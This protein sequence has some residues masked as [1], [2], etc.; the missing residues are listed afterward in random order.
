[1]EQAKYVLF[2]FDFC[3]LFGTSGRL[4]L[5]KNIM[6]V[7]NPVSG[8]GKQAMTIRERARGNADTDH[9]RKENKQQ[10]KRRC[11]YEKCYYVWCRQ[12]VRLCV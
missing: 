6:D 12:I 11:Y 7:R 1:M 2:H 10:L 4:F 3:R 8:P 9:D 5:E